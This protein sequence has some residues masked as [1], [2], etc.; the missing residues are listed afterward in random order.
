MAER[1]QTQAAVI[2]ITGLSGA[3]K[4]STL[5]VLE[6]LGY[7]CIDNL[8]V[9]FLPKFLELSGNFSPTRRGIAV[10]MDVREKEF[11]EHFPPIFR[12]LKN[13]QV[14]PQLLFMEASDGALIKRFSETRRRHPLA[15]ERPVS[16]G[17]RA[18][19]ELLQP[20]RSLATHIV[21]SSRLSVHQLK[22]QIINIVSPGE[23][24]ASLYISLISFGFRHGIPAEADIIMDVRFLPNPYFI[25]ELRPK[26]GLDREVRDFV[27][28][29]ETTR[30]FISR[31][32][33]LLQFLI[34]E[35]RREGKSY[36]TIAIGCTG[37]QHRS[38]AICEALKEHL[39]ASGC[40]LQLTHRDLPGSPT[41]PGGKQ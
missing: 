20:I 36:L 33:G 11:L 5:K 41:A 21:D 29:Q 25:E 16:E 19:R 10:V 27:L 18:E 31:Y 40:R 38:V 6:D 34:P 9:A 26:T 37:G 13:Q 28:G 7:F 35:Y 1:Q 17:I 14:P 2:I 15:I 8:P 32:T 4:S 12:Q 23:A 22:Q 30:E 3:G 39:E 24:P